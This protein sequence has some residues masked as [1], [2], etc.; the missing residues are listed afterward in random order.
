[1]LVCKINI[2]IG[3][4]QKAHDLSPLDLRL[5]YYMLVMLSKLDE[6]K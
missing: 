4:N 1:M 2:G 6:N 5:F 3:G